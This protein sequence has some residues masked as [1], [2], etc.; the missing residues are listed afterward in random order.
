MQHG[1]R[2]RFQHTQPARAGLVFEQNSPAALACSR[3]DLRVRVEGP[4]KHVAGDV[5]AE[6]RARRVPAGLRR[7]TRR[8]ARAEPRVLALA[9]RDVAAAILG[10]A[11]ERVK[12]GPLLPASPRADFEVNQQARRR[13][14]GGPL[15]RKHV[16]PF[17]SREHLAG[18]GQQDAAR[19]SGSEGVAAAAVLLSLPSC[20]LSPTALARTLALSASPQAV[21]PPAPYGVCGAAI[22][23]CFRGE[24]FVASAT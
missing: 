19:G 20:S 3:A 24:Q 1:P 18:H 11:L 5:V 9:R 10:L 23:V 17:R 14:S 8:A 15:E 6:A 13:G 7:G 2:F 4:G 12:D 16:G 22:A 21:A